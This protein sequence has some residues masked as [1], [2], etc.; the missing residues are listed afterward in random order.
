MDATMNFIVNRPHM[1]LCGA[2]TRKKSGHVYI[3]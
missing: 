2:T 1:N 3:L